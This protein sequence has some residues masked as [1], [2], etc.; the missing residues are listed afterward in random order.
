MHEF[1]LRVDDASGDPPPDLFAASGGDAL[2]RL[3]ADSV[4]A[5]IAYYA[6][7]SLQCRFA[8]QRYAQYNGWTPQSILGKTVREVVGEPAWAAIEPHVRQV[9]GGQ[10]VKY[11]REQT[12]PDGSTRMIEVDLVPHFDDAYRQQGAFALC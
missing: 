7:G 11:R 1:P 12:L 6:V 10:P 3:V 4:P 9:I 8:N 5:L 2:L